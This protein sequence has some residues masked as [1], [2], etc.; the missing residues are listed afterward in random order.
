MSTAAPGRNSVFDPRALLRR[1]VRV[2]G[3]VR[4]LKNGLSISLSF[5][6]R[7]VYGNTGRNATLLELALAELGCPFEVH[8]HDSPPRTK[9]VNR[10]SSG[11]TRTRT[12]Q[13]VRVT[14]A[15]GLFAAAWVKDAMRGTCGHPKR[16]AMLTTARIRAR[17]VLAV[18]AEREAAL[19]TPAIEIPEP[20]TPGIASALSCLPEG[21][22]SLPPA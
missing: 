1:F 22:V 8:R 17:Q 19:V 12:V 10:D 9:V 5:T 15:G 7:T 2:Y 14:I 13:S 18:M 16:D 6:F 4:Q 3:R 20:R 11:A 21:L